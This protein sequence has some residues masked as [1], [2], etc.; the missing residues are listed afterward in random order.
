VPAGEAREALEFF[1]RQLH[2]AQP[3]LVGGKLPDARF[4][5]VRG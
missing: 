3:A 4:Y 5:G 1:Y 2:S